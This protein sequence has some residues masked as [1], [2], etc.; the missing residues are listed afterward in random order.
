MTLASR[1]HTYNR[2]GIGGAENG[3]QH[4][5]HI[6]GPIGVKSHAQE[7]SRQTGAENN[8][9]NSKDLRREDGGRRI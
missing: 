8:S 4:K 3:A 9:K 5:G 6:P 2:N 7:D 1:R